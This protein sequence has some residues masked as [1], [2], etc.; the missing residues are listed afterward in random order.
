V[1]YGGGGALEAMRRTLAGELGRRGVRVIT[2]QTGGIPES[3]SDDTP[4][5][6]REAI[7]KASR[8]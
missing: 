4:E 3:I 1:I 7:A 8:T 2:L 5:E 6:A